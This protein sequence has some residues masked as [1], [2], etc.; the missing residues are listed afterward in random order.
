MTVEVQDQDALNERVAS[1]VNTLITTTDPRQIIQALLSTAAEL[2]QIVL[3]AEKATA[4]QLAH[5]FTS[6]LVLALDVP[7]E[8]EPRIQVVPAGVIDLSSRR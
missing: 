1:I 4:S 3:K 2:A 6:A 8:E 5:V 7:V